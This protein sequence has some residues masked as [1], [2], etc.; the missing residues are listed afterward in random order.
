MPTQIKKG[1]YEVFDKR[2]ASWHCPNCKQDSL[3]LSDEYKP[4]I[5]FK[6]NICGFD[7]KDYAVVMTEKSTFN[8]VHRWLKREWP[9]IKYLTDKY[10]MKG[11]EDVFSLIDCEDNK[12]GCC[13]GCE[14]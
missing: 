11:T 14:E 10:Y 4:L 8:S 2:A 9:W 3:K 7:S 1:K 6:C 5:T 12:C 13:S